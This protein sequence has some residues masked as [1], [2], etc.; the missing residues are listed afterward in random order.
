MKTIHTACN[1]LLSAVC[2]ITLIAVPQSHA[3]TE[4]LSPT[5]SQTTFFPLEQSPFAHQVE[6]EQA[7]I[8]KLVSENKVV[9]LRFSPEER[10]NNS[11]RYAQQKDPQSQTNFKNLKSTIQWMNHS[12][13]SDIDKKFHNKVRGLIE[14]ILQ[15]D[16]RAKTELL[17]NYKIAGARSSRITKKDRLVYTWDLANRQLSIYECGNHYKY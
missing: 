6:Q 17:R 11:N 3:G 15:D 12:S 1:L 5:A 4:A 9:G 7:A 14:S 13:M 8:S 2:A 10:K 16:S